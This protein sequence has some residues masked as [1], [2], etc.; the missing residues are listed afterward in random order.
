MSG[1]PLIELSQI[2]RTFDPDERSGVRGVSLTIAEGEFVAI[3]GPSG[4]GKSTLL[5]VLGLLD[6]P[7]SGSY[8]FRGEDIGALGEGARNRLRSS[9]IG[10]VFQSSFVLSD[11][12]AL[13]NAAL[14]LRIQGVPMARRS[15]LAWMALSQLGIRSQWATA[16]R[17]LSGGERQRVA[18]A[19]AIATRPA[20][21][22][23][24]EP[25]G[26]LDTENGEIV[27]S[28]LRKL[29]AGGTTIVIIT[30]DPA[31]AA[32]ADRQIEIVDGVA[33][34]LSI[35]SPTQASRQSSGGAEHASRQS[36]GDLTQR[37]I[38][39]IDAPR[40]LRD[41][42]SDDFADAISALNERLFRSFL[43]A[44][45][46]TLGISGLITSIGL[47]E[48]ASAQVAE[49]LTAA[50]LDE[51]R[52]SPP[53]G[54]QLL[55]EDRET[56]A[57][58]MREL[59]DLPH[60]EEVGYLAMVPA[61]SAHI[62]RLGQDDEQPP[63]EYFLVAASPSYLQMIGAQ[64]QH[65]TSFEFQDDSAIGSAAWIGEDAA[66]GLGITSPGPGS[67][68]WATGRQ[69]DVAGT[70]AA[71]TR[72]P[73]ASRFIVVTPDVIAGLSQV[74]VTI[75][76]RT[77]LGFPATIAEAAPLVLDP[78]SPGTFR[79][80]TVADLRNLRFGVSND[81]GA[82][83]GLLS[84]ILLSLATISASTTMYVSVQSRAHEIALRR[85]IGASRFD[86]ARLFLAEG[87]LVGAVGGASG[88]I[89]GTT[90]GLLTAISRGWTPVLPPEMAFVGVGLGILTG[91]VSAV[92]PAWAAS[93]REPAT[94]IRT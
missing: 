45:A 14:G 12:S 44:L 89:V 91:L 65:G 81:L 56:L 10:F 9:C 84:L 11:Q 73:E 68:M 61:S 47:S 71:G 41:T 32:R 4:A 48:S 50:A 24:D 75:V 77:E 49:R 6:R 63:L 22:L 17:L 72:A 83:I 33:A 53:G 1:L 26:N 39:G 40:R 59:A 51:V 93:R 19:R 28:H 78:A 90:A 35:E 86:V 85:A 64:P 52:I 60:V 69:L 13:S 29:N 87:L 82:L 88:A 62:R 37:P 7:D 66:E 27:I 18:L 54:Y 2:S 57:T 55:G 30:H 16:G 15:A 79:V 5:N 42:L 58:W 25:T 46:F 36:S 23:A 8:F 34:E 70:F 92:V 43:L 38:V 94:A 3:V 31:V 20:L 21:I 74:D 67:T 80:E 76:I